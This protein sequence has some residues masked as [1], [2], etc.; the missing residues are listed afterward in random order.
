MEPEAGRGT[1]LIIPIRRSIEHTFAKILFRRSYK[2]QCEKETWKNKRRVM[3]R[4][5]F[6]EQGL[7]PNPNPCATFKCWAKGWF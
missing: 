7:N 6:P 4:V 3:R 1:R 5:M 2:Q